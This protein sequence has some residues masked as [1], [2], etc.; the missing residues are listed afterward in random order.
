MTYLNSDDQK[1][2]SIE[3]SI[4]SSFIDD[5]LKGLSSNQKYLSSKYFYDDAGSRLF[6]KIMQHP[7]YYLTN[8]EHEI[9]NQQKHDNL[10]IVK[11][12]L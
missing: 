10:K 12:L 8:C 11:K 5:V 4:Q 7:D 2:D 3:S 9:F 6:E 1:G